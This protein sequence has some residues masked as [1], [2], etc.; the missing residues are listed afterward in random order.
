MGGADQGCTS[1]FLNG[2]AGMMIVGMWKAVEAPER[3]RD[4][5]IKA[6]MA[7]VK[8]TAHRVYPTGGTAYSI[9]KTSKNKEMAWAFLQE[10]LGQAGFEAAYKEATL[11]AIY[12]Q[13]NIPAF[14][15]YA[16]QPIKFLDTLQPNADARSDIRF[17]RS[18]ELE[19][20]HSNPTDLDLDFVLNG[21]KPV[22]EA[23]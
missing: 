3:F 17:A 2:K 15:W 6:V 4:L 16:K 21:T 23:D 8:D 22:E 12:P 11:G 10:F 20:T 18:C 7:P 13:A 19:R 5:G 14:E 9:L 1:L